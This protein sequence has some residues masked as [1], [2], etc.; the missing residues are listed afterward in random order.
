MFTPYGSLTPSAIEIDG[1]SYMVIQIY[2]G[3]N[4]PVSPLKV[5][6]SSAIGKKEI[7]III[8]GVKAIIPRQGTGATYN[9]TNDANANII[10]NYMAYN[11]N[12][13]FP[14]TLLI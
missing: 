1:K 14:V 5:V 10:I 2:A 13:T 12:R 3:F 7:G 9:I 11:L 4:I 8:N 6:F